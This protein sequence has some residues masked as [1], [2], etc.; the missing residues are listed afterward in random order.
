MDEVEARILVA[1]VRADVR[2]GAGTGLAVRIGDAGE[3]LVVAELAVEIHHLVHL[4][5]ADRIICVGHV[6]I[7][8]G[9]E[10]NI[11]IAAGRTLR[12]LVVGRDG[13][14]EPA[15]E[16]VADAVAVG[17]GRAFQE[18]AAHVHVQAEVA[19][20]RVVARLGEVLA[21]PVEARVVPAA[22]GVAIPEIEEVGIIATFHVDRAGKGVGRESEA[23]QVHLGIEEIE[24]D[25][26][27][28]GLEHGQDAAA[29]LEGDDG[30]GGFVAHFQRLNHH[31]R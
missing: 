19:L 16:L 26:A 6:A 22:H 31:R 25:R 13:D 12:I 17:L 14:V 9:E 8:A 29:V 2:V 3:E 11:G 5:V 10:R 28:A 24:G 1:L 7:I 23:G 20:V 27:F 21:V 30:H 4:A 18:I 15:V